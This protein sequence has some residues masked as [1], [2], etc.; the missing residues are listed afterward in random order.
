MVQR[1]K[2]QHAV[3]HARRMAW[4]IIDAQVCCNVRGQDSAG[5]ATAR[6]VITPAFVSKATHNCAVLAQ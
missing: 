5:R 6:S 4:A 3:E 1:G 2:L